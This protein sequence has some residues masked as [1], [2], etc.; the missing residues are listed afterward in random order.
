MDYKEFE[1]IGTGNVKGN[2]FKGWRNECTF[3]WWIFFDCM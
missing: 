3:A 2:D 1:W